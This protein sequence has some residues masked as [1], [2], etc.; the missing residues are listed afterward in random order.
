MQKTVAIEKLIP[1]RSHTNSPIKLE[2][3]KNKAIIS[4]KNKG[5]G[6][7]PK[8]VKIPKTI[9]ISEETI[10]LMGFF[11]GDGLKSSNGAASRT[12]SFTNSEPNPVKWAMRLFRCDSCGNW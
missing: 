10:A 8:P 4:W 5:G 1:K 9:T 11:L 7:H 2:I 12:L 3:K 6:Q